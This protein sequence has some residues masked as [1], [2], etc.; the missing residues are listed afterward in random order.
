LSAL[1]DVGT[2]EE[3]K[4]LLEPGIQK[5]DHGK[6]PRM[7]DRPASQAPNENHIHSKKIFSSK[8]LPPAHALINGS[9]RPIFDEIR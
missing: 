8:L 1:F 6:I 4:Y 7:S 5:H 9:H 2:Q 3:M